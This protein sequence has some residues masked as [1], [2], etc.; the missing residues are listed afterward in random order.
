MLKDEWDELNTRGLKGMVLEADCEITHEAEPPPKPKGEEKARMA[1]M[2]CK[3]ADFQEY[4]EW[5]L[6][7]KNYPHGDASGEKMAADLIYEVCGIKSRAELDHNKDA[8]DKFYKMYE[9][10]MNWGRKKQNSDL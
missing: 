2:L 3:Q 7:F 8:A 1:G 6:S 10:F 5:A 4:A 9:K